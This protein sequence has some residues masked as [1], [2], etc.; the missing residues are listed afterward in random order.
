MNNIEFG[1][2]VDINDLTKQDRVRVRIPR[3]H[4]HEIPDHMLHWCIVGKPTTAPSSGGKGRSHELLNGS[5]VWGSFID[6]DD[7]QQFIVM[8][9][10]DGTPADRG[11]DPDGIYPKILNEPDTNRL[12]RN[13]RVNETSIGEINNNRISFDNV[14]K[15]KYTEEISKY[16]ATYP[17]NKVY[18]S[19]AGHIVEFDSTPGN[20][21]YHMREPSKNYTESDH[22]GNSAQKIYGDR[23]TYIMG[24]DIEYVKGNKVLTVDGN[25]TIRVKKDF[26]LEIDGNQSVWIKK[27][28]EELI[29]GSFTRFV[30][31]FKQEVI[32]LHYH[33]WAR[34]VDINNW[35]RKRPDPKRGN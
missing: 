18:E 19:E 24:D 6:G 5:V 25:I 23:K 13:S 7:M 20:T 34:P 2:V 10:I 29:E 17:Y 22:D 33:L 14:D 11:L 21:R 8:G 28:K 31:K 12:A 30:K 35:K 16:N 4:T 9:S 15:I 3:L 32:K 1:F 26:I 27:D